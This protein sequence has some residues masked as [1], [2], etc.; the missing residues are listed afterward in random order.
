METPLELPHI[1]GKC[2]EHFTYR[3]FI[4]CSDSWKKHPVSNI[5]KQLETYRAIER[6][7]SD[8]LDPVCSTFG[9]VILTYGF[10][11]PTLVAEVKKNKFPNITP[12]GDQH[13]GCELNS[14]GNLICSRRGIAVDFYVSGRSSLEIARWVVRETKFDR[15]YFYSPHRPFHVSVGPEESRSI[16]WMDGYRGGRHQPRVL[17]SEVFQGDDWVGLGA[18]KAFQR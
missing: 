12:A 3:D 18:D 1:D 2:G 11:S 9:E 10:S 6:L 7:C 13:A 8:I 4:E 5:P 14:R 17:K 15:L 16:V